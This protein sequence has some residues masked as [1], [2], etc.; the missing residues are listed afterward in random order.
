[1]DNVT[2]QSLKE[3]YYNLTGKLADDDLNTFFSFINTLILMDI[4]DRVGTIIKKI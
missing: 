3:Q 2:F 4:K 1:M